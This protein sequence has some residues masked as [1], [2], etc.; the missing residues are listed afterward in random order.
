MEIVTQRDREWLTTVRQFEAAWY[1]WCG[2]ELAAPVGGRLVACVAAD[3]GPQCDGEVATADPAL[4]ER[5]DA[6]RRARAF[7][8]SHES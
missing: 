6:Q 1:G 3:G 8:E 4:Q 5:F 2:N 7:A